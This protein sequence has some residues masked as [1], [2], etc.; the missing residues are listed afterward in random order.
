MAFVL[1]T[2]IR[3]NLRAC[4]YDVRPWKCGCVVFCMR[5]FIRV[6]HHAWMEAKFGAIVQVSDKC[7][8]VHTCAQ[9]II[10]LL[11]VFPCNEIACI[12]TIEVC[13]Y[14][15]TVLQC[16]KPC[17]QITVRAIRCAKNACVRLIV[18][19]IFEAISRACHNIFEH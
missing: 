8:F 14:A 11:S 19:E 7:T 10:T 18:S 9:A 1:G 13:V 17:V 4:K 5:L 6:M 12:H 15:H 3:A 2:V 16:E